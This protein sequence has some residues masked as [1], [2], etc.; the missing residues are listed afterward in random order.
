MKRKLCRILALALALILVLGML[1]VS[2]MKPPDKFNIWVSG[3]QITVANKDDVLGDGGGVAAWRADDG[4]TVGVTV[5][6]VDMIG[7]D[8][9]RG[10]QVDRG[11]VEQRSVAAC[12][13]ADQ[14]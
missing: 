8:G 9:R 10:H 13:R 6:L 7:A 11:S 5:I 14:Q 1:P 2:A 12:T 3:T 4:D